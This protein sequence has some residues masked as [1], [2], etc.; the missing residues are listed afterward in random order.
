MKIITLLSIFIFF[1]FTVSPT[2][3]DFQI[4]SSNSFFVNFKTIDNNRLKIQLVNDSKDSLIYRSFFLKLVDYD[5]V[6]LNNF[7]KMEFNNG[8]NILLLKDSISQC[9]S[10]VKIQNLERK[11]VLV[12]KFFPKKSEILSKSVN[13]DENILEVQFA[14][15]KKNFFFEYIIQKPINFDQSK[16]KVQ[17]DKLACQENFSVSF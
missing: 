5:E 8:K 9:F 2:K 14:M 16:V 1:G 7:F 4:R 15:H 13:K 3:D 17:V 11:V 6:K 10:W 12:N